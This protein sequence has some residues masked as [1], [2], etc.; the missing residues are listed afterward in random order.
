MEE[1]GIPFRALMCKLC[2]KQSIGRKR[3]RWVDNID[4]RDVGLEGTWQNGPC[5]G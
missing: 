2:R 1:E 4:A 5:I 3:R